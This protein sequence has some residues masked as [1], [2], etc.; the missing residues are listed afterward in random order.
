MELVPYTDADRWLTEALETD[1][2]VMA[3]LGGAWPVDA[4][5]AIHA[6]RMDSIAAGTWWFTIVL[7]PGE[8]PIGMIGIFGSDIDSRP[9]SEAGWSILP[10]FHGRGYASAALGMLLER[11]REDGRWGAIHALPGVS[12]GPSNGLCRKFG[13]TLVGELEVD[14]AGRPLRCNHWV[15]E[16]STTRSA[17]SNRRPASHA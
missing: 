14:Y 8:A 2:T 3:E 11:A 12:N 16:P 13:F 1:A 15:L 4:I 10:A 17:P 7:A 9:V 6:R 5:P